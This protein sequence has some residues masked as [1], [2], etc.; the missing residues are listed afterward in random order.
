MEIELSGGSSGGLE[1]ALA[2]VQ[3]RL[4][5]PFGVDPQRF[6]LRVERPGGARL[7]L[8]SAGSGRYTLSMRPGETLRLSLDD[9]FGEYAQI[10]RFASQTRDGVDEW[11]LRPVLAQRYGLTV[12]DP[13]GE[14]AR[15]G[16]ARVTAGFDL[17]PE[18]PEPNRSVIDRSS[19]PLEQG[20]VTLQ[21]PAQLWRLRI[22]FD[23]GWAE[24]GPFEAG[25]YTGPSTVQLQ[26]AVLATGRV[27]RGDVPVVGAQVSLRPLLDAGRMMRAG[28]LPTRVSYGE[29]L[30]TTTTDAA[31][32]YRLQ[33]TAAAGRSIGVELDGDVLAVVPLVGS[34]VPDIDLSA[35]GRVQGRVHGIGGE[36]SG[37]IV[38][39]WNGWGLNRSV[40]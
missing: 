23:T 10:E 16:V 24:L 37:G 39:A 29:P 18:R 13:D 38:T 19:S 32:E 8:E 31:G 26:T 33:P 36:L 14:P 15:S 35:A 21:A 7:E 11:V 17:P 6:E 40:V 1:G 25:V 22:V 30:Q 12:L 4:E 3:V 27:L 28:G 2:Q 5:L 34:Q 9:L 20:A